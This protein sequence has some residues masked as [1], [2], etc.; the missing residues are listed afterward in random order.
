RIPPP[1]VVGAGREPEADLPIEADD[2]LVGAIV[3]HVG[4]DRIGRLRVRRVVRIPVAGGDGQEVPATVA[5]VD[6]VR[7]DELV[8]VRVVPRIPE[9]RARHRI[10]D[11]GDAA[12]PYLTPV[13]RP[14]RLDDRLAIAL[15]VVGQTDAR[16]DVVEL[17]ARISTR[18]IDGRQ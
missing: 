3:L 1:D 2:E 10:D 14:V 9:A 18:E 5:N 13:H 17:D 11:S 6:F 7:L 4:I 16:R 12:G 8:A 15:Q